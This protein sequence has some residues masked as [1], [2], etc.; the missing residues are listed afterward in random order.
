VYD[1]AR[2][3]P[4]SPSTLRLERYGHELGL[5]FKVHKDRAGA[6]REAVCRL[7]SH[8][9]GS[10]LRLEVDGDLQRSQ[11]CRSHDEVMDTGEAWKAAM[12]EKGWQ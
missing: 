3:D 9:L 4:S 1:P 5:F 10:E 7:L 11:V 12:I 6:P 2:D 8:Q